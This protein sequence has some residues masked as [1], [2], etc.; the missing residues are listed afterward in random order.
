MFI[1]LKTIERVAREQ[2]EGYIAEY[3]SESAEDD[4]GDYVAM[5]GEITESSLR[6]WSKCKR[7]AS[8]MKFVRENTSLSDDVFA[9]LGPMY[10]FELYLL[11]VAKE[12]NK[13]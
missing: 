6:Y 8:Y 3:G 13:P 4:L 2:V 9:V 7:N 5:R 12:I 1:S 11:D 10:A